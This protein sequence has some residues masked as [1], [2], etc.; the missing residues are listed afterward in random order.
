MTCGYRP[1][2]KPGVPYFAGYGHPQPIRAG[3]A[4]LAR[5]GSYRACEPMLQKDRHMQAWETG[6]LY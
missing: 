5:H 4:H 1:K 2:S 3:Y 6:S